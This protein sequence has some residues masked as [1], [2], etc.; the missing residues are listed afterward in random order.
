MKDGRTT[1]PP[2]VL[3]IDG[4]LIFER[5]DHMDGGN[6]TCYAANEQGTISA[7]IQVDIVGE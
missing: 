4:T 3:S 7:T 6:Y 2:N 5:A 1:L